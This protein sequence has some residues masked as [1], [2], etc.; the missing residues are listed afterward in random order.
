[1]VIASLMTLSLSTLQNVVNV[2]NM[3]KMWRFAGMMGPVTELTQEQTAV[4][5]FV[6]RFADQLVE[7]GMPRMP[8]R[9]F[10]R[11]LVSDTGKLSAAELSEHLQ[12]SPAAVSGGIRYL[13]QVDLVKR[14]RPPGSRRD[15]YVVSHD[16]WHEALTRRD[17]MLLRWAEVLRSGAQSLGEATPAGQRVLESADF[18]E[19]IAAE[20]P[21][22]LARWRASR[23]LI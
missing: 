23:G 17:A 15:V 3:M 11:L 5:D 19:F 2:L 16:A 10:V 7:G 21:A 22:L 8:A 20:V 6:E 18:F 9:I 12:I 13:G 1:M 4:G 14:E